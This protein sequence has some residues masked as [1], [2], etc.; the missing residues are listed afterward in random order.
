M[1]MPVDP[2]VKR[3]FGALVWSTRLGGGRLRA[4]DD[5]ERRG[6]EGCVNLEFGDTPDAIWH[7]RLSR[8]GVRFVSGPAEKP[9]GTVRLSAD[10]FLQLLGG[11][12]SLSTAQMTGRVLVEG[13]GHSSMVLA[14]LIGQ[15]R[16]RAERRGLRGWL[17][18]RF[19]RSVLRKS[20]TRHE[21]TLSQ[22]GSATA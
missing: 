10:V 19:L 18:R 4:K 21:L 3:F 12:T 5:V 13:D 9:L 7:C 17:A 16:L 8:Q 14:S 2:G 6:F 1:R 15:T 20:P 22:S 11:G